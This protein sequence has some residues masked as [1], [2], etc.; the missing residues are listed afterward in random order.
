[1]QGETV[2]TGVDQLLSLLR[3]RR[4][5]SLEEASKLLKTPEKTVQAWVDFL[6]EEHILGLEYKFTKPYIYMGAEHVSAT[7]AEEIKADITTFMRE[8]IAKA[9]DNKI[10]ADKAKTLWNQH[11]DQQLQGKREFF[12]R[13][14][15][16][17]GLD[18]NL[19]WT[20]YQEYLHSI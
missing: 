6:V 8:Y 10:P 16:S 1:M 11:L 20:K 14:A 15:R 3:Q 12:D 5:I 19:L 7:A 17:R 2:E 4:K 18:P 9:A 13:E